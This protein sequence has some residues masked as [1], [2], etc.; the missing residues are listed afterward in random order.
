MPFRCSANAAS[1]TS[2]RPTCSGCLSPIWLTKP[3]TARR[4][5]Q[6]VG[7]VLDWAKAAGFRSGENPVAGV[8]KGLPKQPDRDDHHAALP[9]A[10]VPEFIQMLRL[11]DAGETGKLAFEFLILTATRTAEVLGAKWSEMDL[12]Q[13]TWTDSGRA[14]EV[15]AQARCP[16]ARALS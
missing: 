7:T 5:R 8:G 10:K 1:I 9:Y 2:I 11:T 6:R 3:E 16:I 13:K 4:V 12:A 15:G 14:H